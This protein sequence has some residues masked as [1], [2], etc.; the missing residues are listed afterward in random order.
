MVTL[1]YRQLLHSFTIS[2]EK[3]I[4][5]DFSDE[6]F[7]HCVKEDD[8]NTNTNLCATKKPYGGSRGTQT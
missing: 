8:D 4:G 3:V 7:F 5:M 6:T 1:C 2:A